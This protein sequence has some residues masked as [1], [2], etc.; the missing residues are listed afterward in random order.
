[1]GS[2]V[3]KTGGAALGVAR[4]VRL[5]CAPARIGPVA[6]SPVT[7]EWRTRTDAMTG[8]RRPPSVDALLREIEPESDGRD[9]GALV[10]LAREV[11]AE[12]RARLAS[13]GSPAQLP[14]LGIALRERLE[15]LDP[16]VRPEGAASGLTPV[17]NATGRDPPHQSRPRGL[18][19][20][21]DR[22]GSGRRGRALPPRARSRDRAPR[23]ALQR[24]RGRGR[25]PDRRRGGPRDEQQRRRGGARGW[26]RGPRQRG[27]LS[28]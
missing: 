9:R 5:P 7:A 4:W 3:F 19:R 23:P 14:A 13:G 24:R 27:R 17:I 21:G 16:D 20:R 15:A 25:R 2:L 11:V 22:G 12:E 10:A 28:G 8:S 1:M 26:A 18:A 6:P